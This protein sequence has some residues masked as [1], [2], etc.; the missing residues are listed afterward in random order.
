M[1]GDV[2]STA[3]IAHGP[4]GLLCLALLYGLKVVWKRY[5]DLW[6]KYDEIQKARL[7]D[8]DSIAKALVESTMTIR[9][10]VEAWKK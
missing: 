7:S 1:E 3:L 2:L 9:E 6:L 5:D 4:L 10:F 8:R